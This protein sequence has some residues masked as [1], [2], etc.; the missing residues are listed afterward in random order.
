[1]KT[2]VIVSAR[3]NSKRLPRKALVDI[4]GI[5][6]VIH[7]CKRAAL[8]KRVDVVYLA[9][10]SQEIKAVGDHYGIPVIMT[11]SCHTNSSERAAEA[12]QSIDADIVVNVQ[13]D[14]P[15]V[16]PDHIDQVLE[17][18][19]GDNPPLVAMGVTQFTKKN[20]LGDIKAVFDEKGKILYASRHD[21][22]CFF[23]QEEKPMWKMSFIVPFQKSVLQKYLVWKATPLELIEDNHF[24]RI[25]EN[26]IDIQ[27][28]VIDQAKISVDS[29]ED[30]EEVRNEM[31][32]DKIKKQYN[33]K[34][35]VE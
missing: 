27:A 4:D 29:A 31:K 2:A 12:S 33:Q 13:G 3:L 9:T 30:L 7:T 34:E 10:D 19:F 28:V 24:L 17:P 1:M 21:I 23:G 32:R 25:I 11:D 35:T 16:Y 8:A 22:P 18:M 26:G 5:P 20:S 6:M 15:L 14:E